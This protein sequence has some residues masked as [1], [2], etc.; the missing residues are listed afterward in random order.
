MALPAS[1]TIDLLAIQT[2]FSTSGLAASA[3][4]GIPSTALVG[5]D[6]QPDRSMQDF[7]GR[8]ASVTLNINDGSSNYGSVSYDGFVSD[9]SHNGGESGVIGGLNPRTGTL[10]SGNIVNFYESRDI[11]DPYPHF[12]SLVFNQAQ[13]YTG[14]YVIKYNG[15]TVILAGSGYEW[16][17]SLSRIEGFFNGY[18]LGT[19]VISTQ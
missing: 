10:W 7:Y 9:P 15:K 5:S 13:S 14:N 3:V 17:T 16:G 2:E 18:G 19:V 6:L 12:I 4:A 1:G 8:S 11:A